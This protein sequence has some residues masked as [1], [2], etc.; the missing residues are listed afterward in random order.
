MNA[1]EGEQ[2]LQLLP[3]NTVGYQSLLSLYLETNGTVIKRVTLLQ[4]FCLLSLMLPPQQREVC[5]S[6]KGYH[7]ARARVSENKAQANVK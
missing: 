6:H 2:M 1:L 7:K 4:A 5:L 3:I